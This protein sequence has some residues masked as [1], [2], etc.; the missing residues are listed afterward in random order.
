MGGLRYSDNK[1][2]VEFLD[3]SN[4]DNF[5]KMIKVLALHNKGMNCPSC[6]STHVSK[7]GHRRGKHTLHLLQLPPPI[8]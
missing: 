2:F 7:N 5:S 1:R 6:E 3:K 4:A 8:C